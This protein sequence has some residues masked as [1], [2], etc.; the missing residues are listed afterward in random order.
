MK[1]IIPTKISL[2]F[3]SAT[4]AGGAASTTDIELAQNTAARIDTDL[5]AAITAQTTYQASVAAL[6]GKY[7]AKTLATDNAYDFAVK[8]KN[9]LKVY[10]GAQFCEAW[11]D[12]GF[13]TSLTVP[14]SAEELESLL[15]ALRAHFVANPSHENAP[16]SVTA[17]AALTLFNSLK[18]ARIAVNDQRSD[19]TDKRF[20]REDAVKQLRRRLR[21]LLNELDQLIEPL[22]ARWLSF[23]FNMP[24]APE[25][26]AVPQNVVVE[27]LSPGELHVTCDASP[28]ADHYRFWKQVLGALTEPELAG[29]SD[30]PAFVV[31][32]LTAGVTYLISVSAVSEGGNE[33][34]RSEPVSAIPLAA[35]A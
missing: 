11:V 29:S 5:Q 22:D 14:K 18:N 32:G 33:S 13:L 25:V 12:A 20:L 6:P 3:A 31:E 9:V 7:A 17:A 24:G 34:L 19:A 4:A 16:L 10:C 15:T 2:L 21:G 30:E 23:G 27:A 1:N 35:A 28:L 8:A 26:P